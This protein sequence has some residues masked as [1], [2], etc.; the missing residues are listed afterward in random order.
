VPSLYPGE[1]REAVEAVFGLLTELVKR[2]ALRI[3]SITDS[4]R[5]Y[6]VVLRCG[7]EVLIVPNLEITSQSH[8]GTD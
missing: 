5:R 4:R 3:T 8:L 6:T 7:V 1:K 2:K